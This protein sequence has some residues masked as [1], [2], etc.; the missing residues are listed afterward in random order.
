MRRKLCLPL[1]TVFSK[2][3]HFPSSM[4][5]LLKYF[6]SEKKKPDLSHT[7]LSVKVYIWLGDRN[8]V[9]G[10]LIQL[11]NGVKGQLCS[12]KNFRHKGVDG[13]FEGGKRYFPVTV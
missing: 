5:L 10:I 11:F 7:H 1:Q 12:L 8:T 6:S 3:L 9:F 13:E 4:F 2:S